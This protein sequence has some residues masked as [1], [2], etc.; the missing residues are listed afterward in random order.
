MIPG[1]I[2]F[3]IF[4]ISGQTIVEFAS[5][6]QVR[7]QANNVPAWR[8]IVNSKWF[9]MKLLSDDE[10]AEI[11]AAKV[12]KLDVEIEAIDEEIRKTKAAEEHTPESN[13]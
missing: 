7:N 5:R 6:Q 13:E 10:Y 2:M 11:L 4:G 8:R 12:L 9:P 1:A 3:S